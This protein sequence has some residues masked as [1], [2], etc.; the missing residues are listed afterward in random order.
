MS[1]AT[2][3]A[4]TS[5]GP[6]LPAGQRGNML[7]IRKASQA[8]IP[9]IAKLARAIWPAC[10]PIFLTD[11][12]IKAMLDSIYAPDALASEMQ[13]GHVFWIASEQGKDLGFASAYMDDDGQTMWLKKLYIRPEAQCRGVGRALINAAL[14]HFTAAT[15][16]ALYVNQNNTPAISCYEHMGFAIDHEEAVKMGPF[17]FIDCVMIKRL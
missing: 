1:P 2:W 7:E 8:D 10:F 13:R 12:Q 15:R 3:A 17:D 16:I 5:S 9:T 11:E 6:G 14:K 4:L